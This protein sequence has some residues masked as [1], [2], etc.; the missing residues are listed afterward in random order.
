VPLGYSTYPAGGS[1]QKFGFFSVHVW[2]LPYMEANNVYQLIDFSKGQSKKMTSGGVPINPQYN[3]YA[4]ANNLFLCPSDG[5]TGRVITE[6]NYR[7]NF[8]GS[9]PYAGGI[10]VGGKAD[11]TAL[12]SEGFPAGGN[13]AFTMGSKGLK[14]SAFTD[15][16]SKTAFFSERTKGSGNDAANTAPTKY[17]IVGM[18]QGAA[19]LPIE[20]AFTDCLNEPRTPD[21]RN[22]TGAG[23]WLEGSDWSNGWPFAGYDSTQYNHVAPPNWEGIDCGLHS[24]IPDTPDEHAIIAPRS[25]HPGV[26]VVAFGDGHTSIIND[27]IELS[28]WRPLG[29]RDGGENVEYE[30]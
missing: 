10:N 8:G 26:V 17:D 1:G 7:V 24:G 16:L 30:P 14:A 4:T 5:N 25:E 6:N 21:S 22:L 19:L 13:G 27:G 3:A 11:P 20:K 18:G 29:T 2:I 28:V 23:R 12:S 9:T 15:G